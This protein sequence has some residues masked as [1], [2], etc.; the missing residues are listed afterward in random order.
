MSAQTGHRATAEGTG[1]GSAR[2]LRRPAWSPATAAGAL[3]AAGLLLF[4]ASLR[5]VDL[6]RMNGLGLLS[7]LPAGALAG[8]VL[9][10][11]AFAGG[12]ALPTAR[13]VVLVPALAS[14]VVCLDG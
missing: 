1:A 9:V 3:T 4:F 2:R 10:A 6:G 13:R 12:L 11:L 14:L 7:V 5:A 8:V